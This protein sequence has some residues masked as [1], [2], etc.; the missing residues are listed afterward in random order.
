MKRVHK[1]WGQL[2]KI[3][4]RK[5]ADTQDLEMLYREVVQAV[6]LFGSEF[7]VMLASMERKVVSTHTGFT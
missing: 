4:G 7:L 6:M 3:M 2:G 5:G 1:V